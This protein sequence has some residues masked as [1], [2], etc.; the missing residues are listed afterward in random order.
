MTRDVICKH[1]PAV[2][3]HH[4]VITFWHTLYS[5][6][7]TFRRIASSSGIVL[8]PEE[9]C[10]FLGRHRENLGQNGAALSRKCYKFSCNMIEPEAIS[11]WA[12]NAGYLREF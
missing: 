5:V 10:L 12:L 11:I 1:V 6:G 7:A 4:R 8:Q 9:L 3:R 2:W